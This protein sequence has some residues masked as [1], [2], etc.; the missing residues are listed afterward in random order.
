MY[1][2]GLQRLET[3]Q[4]LRFGRPFRPM[5]S[6]RC[7]SVLSVMFVHCGQTV[8]RIKTELGMQVC[9][10]LGHIVLDGDPARLPQKGG[11][12]SPKFSDHVYY[13]YCDFVRTLHRRKALLVCSSSSLVF[14]AFYF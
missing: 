1:N 8:G 11:G 3:E 4:A 9:L 10:G 13:S 5:L 6:D 2:A 12:A 7:V 14:Y